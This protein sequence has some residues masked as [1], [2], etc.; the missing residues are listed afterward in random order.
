MPQAAAIPC[1]EAF[2]AVRHGGGGHDGAAGGGVAGRRGPAALLG[3]AAAPW[4]LDD[5]VKGWSAAVLLAYGALSFLG[6]IQWGLGGVARPDGAGLAVRLALSV[7]PSLAAWL[8]LL[9][10]VRPGLLVRASSL[11]AVLAADL[12]AAQRGLAP[13]WYPK[14]RLPL[15]GGAMVALLAGAL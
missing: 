11:A 4:L 1:R 8:A 7:V 2:G 12:R 6:G 10:P 13:P 14:L 9:L 3:L 15:S 5:S